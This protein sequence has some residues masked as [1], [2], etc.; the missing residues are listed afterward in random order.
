LLGELIPSRWAFEAVVVTQFKDNKFEKDFYDYDRDMAI[1]EYKTVYL[2][3]TLQGRLTYCLNNLDSD[4]SLIN[5]QKDKNMALLKAE[6]E[7]E[8]ELVGADKLN[9]RDQ[10]NSQDFDSVTF[11]ETNLF[12]QV[13][14]RLYVKKGKVARETKDKEIRDRTNTIEKQLAF[15]E[16][17]DHYENTGVIELVEN[18]ITADRILEYDGELIQKIYPIYYEP[19]Y[20]KTALDF[21]TKFFAPKK[22]FAGVLIDT[23]IFNVLILWVMILVMVFT[24]YFDLLRKFIELFDRGYPK[25]KA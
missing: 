25:V 23:L 17:R 3:P 19:I 12:L 9:V 10:F 5:I 24:L 15:Y 11:N 4:D 13:L 2:I 16:L 6:I 22:H 1:S 21:R 14:N 8:L 20:P 7:K 18:K